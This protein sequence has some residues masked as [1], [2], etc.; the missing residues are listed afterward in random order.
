MNCIWLKVILTPNY[1]SVNTIYLPVFYWVCFFYSHCVKR[2]GCDTL[3]VCVCL[4]DFMVMWLHLMLI[5][6][7]PV[8]CNASIRHMLQL[9]SIVHPSIQVEPSQ[10]NRMTLKSAKL[11]VISR[12]ITFSIVPESNLFKHWTIWAWSNHGVPSSFTEWNK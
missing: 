4:H 7:M 1:F 2:A 11:F 10:M 5:R 6:K 12:E 3:W 8:P 9:K